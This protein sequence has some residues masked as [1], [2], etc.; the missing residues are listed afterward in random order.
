MVGGL[1]S[2]RSAAH[3]VRAAE[4]AAAAGVLPDPEL[5]AR[6]LHLFREVSGYTA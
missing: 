3:L 2:A 1:Q 5:A 6:R 4:L